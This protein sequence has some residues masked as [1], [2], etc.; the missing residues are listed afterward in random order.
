MADGVF[1]PDG[2]WMWT[3]DEWIP[4]PPNS[5]PENASDIVGTPVNEGPRAQ[6]ESS[7][8]EPTSATMPMNTMNAPP[9]SSRKI[10]QVI[11]SGYPPQMEV[12][13]TPPSSQTISQLPSGYPP[14]MEVKETPPIPVGFV[15]GGG[16]PLAQSST[17]PIAPEAQPISQQGM[18]MEMDSRQI[19]VPWVGVGLIVFSL[20]LPYW[21]FLGIG[22]SGFELM[23]ASGEV[24]DGFCPQVTYDGQDDCDVKLMFV[25][26]TSIFL[27]SPVIYLLS[28][29][30]GGVLIRMK[31]NPKIL[32]IIHLG[33]FGL[34]I[35]CELL[36]LGTEDATVGAG[37]AMGFYVGSLAPGL[38]FLDGVEIRIMGDLKS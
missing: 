30:I 22:T 38:W 13:E 18:P 7:I 27:L 12:K 19:V 24:F 28:A 16:P 8:S 5:E 34:F 32:A 21:S 11:P 9:P 36:L 33:C 20:L 15:Q 17:G 2:R 1:S 35:I 31:K 6:T 29:I 37:A 25:V 23:G 14:Q 26:S 4:A 10:S 3:G